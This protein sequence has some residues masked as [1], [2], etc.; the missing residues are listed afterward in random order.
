RANADNVAA[1]LVLSV[2]CDANAQ[3]A[4]EQLNR[5]LGA[6]TLVVASGGIEAD[7]TPK[8]HA[9][10]RLRSPTL[11]E[12]DHAK[13]YLARQLACALMGGYHTSITLVHPLRWAGS[14][15]RKS[16]PRM[17][18]IVGQTDN[19]IDLDHAYAALFNAA[20]QH[21]LVDCDGGGGGVGNPEKMASSLD[22]VA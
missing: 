22:D 7:G 4:I 13:L 16:E 12:D 1:G 15:H 9:H 20:E 18:R 6:P 17:A 21:D 8:L 3:Q 14:W 2:E 10:W 5:L 11:M 19:E